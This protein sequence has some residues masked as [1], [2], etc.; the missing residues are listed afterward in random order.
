RALAGEI[1]WLDA[2]A[3]AREGQA[4]GVAL[5]DREGEHPVHPL[6]AGRPPVREGLEDHFRIAVRE[7]A[8]AS[9]LQDLSKLAV[10]VY[11][12]VEDYRQP[13]LRIVH[14]L[15]RALGQVD[16][17]KPSMGEPQWAARDGAG[18]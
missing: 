10:V 17:R 3:V 8:V 4:I 7:E 11:A 13:Q 1:E 5:V 12:A 18:G 15:A 6:D 14:R 9:L 16:D 2:E